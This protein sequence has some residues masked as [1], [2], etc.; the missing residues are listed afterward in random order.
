M[1]RRTPKSDTTPMAIQI[2]LGVV[3]PVAA[4]AIAYHDIRFRWSFLRFGNR[5]MSVANVGWALVGWPAAVNGAAFIA[6]ALSL[7]AFFLAKRIDSWRTALRWSGRIGL[8]LFLVL[9]ITAQV[10]GFFSH[11]DYQR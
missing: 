3:L 11:V 2:A 9:A 1:A 5:E 7:H 4:L 8:I 6:G 10:G